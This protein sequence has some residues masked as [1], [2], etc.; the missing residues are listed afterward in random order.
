M[1]LLIKN[2]R[3]SKSLYIHNQAVDVAITSIA[4]IASD[5]TVTWNG[6]CILT[7]RPN[8][9]YLD[10]YGISGAPPTDA[11]YTASIEL[12]WGHSVACAGAQ[13]KIVVLFQANGATKKQLLARSIICRFP[14]KSP[15]KSKPS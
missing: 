14:E 5:V 11:G 12:G 10:L 3:H 8:A 1:I 6:F 7:L 9:S 13:W 4:R 2:Y 15:D